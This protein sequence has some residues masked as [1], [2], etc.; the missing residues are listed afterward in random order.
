M[1]SFERTKGVIMSRTAW[2][3]MA[4]VL[5]CSGMAAAED[6]WDAVAS[7][8][9]NTLRGVCVADKKHAWAVGDKGTILATA[10]GGKT[11]ASQK[12][13]SDGTLRAVN[14]LNALEG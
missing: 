7:G 9:E 4:A 8:T 1:N 6:R 14:F 5:A 10:D 2:V 3:A 13:E 12:S 11:W